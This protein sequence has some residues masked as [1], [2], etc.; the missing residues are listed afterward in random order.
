MAVG[1][2]FAS[3]EFLYSSAICVMSSWQDVT[4][5]PSVAVLTSMLGC[6]CEVMK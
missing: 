1:Y 4:V 5:W 6:V 3:G 2:C